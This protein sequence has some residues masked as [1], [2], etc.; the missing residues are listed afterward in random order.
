MR[1]TSFFQFIF[2]CLHLLYKCQNRQCKALPPETRITE[3]LQEPAVFHIFEVSPL[4]VPIDE[5]D[6]P[7]GGLRAGLQ[8]VRSIID[9]PSRPAAAACPC[10]IRRIAVRPVAGGYVGDKL[11]RCGSIFRRSDGSDPFLRR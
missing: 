10:E 5:K 3:H 9:L 1:V 6:I 8:M 11:H 2:Y 4:H 7:A